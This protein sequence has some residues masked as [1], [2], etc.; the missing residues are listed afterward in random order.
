MKRKTQII[1]AAI[2]LLAVTIFIFAVYALT[3]A[4]MNDDKSNIGTDVKPETETAAAYTK[5]T[6][7]G[8]EIYN[9]PNMRLTAETVDVTDTLSETPTRVIELTAE[10]LP[11][12]AANKS[13]TWSV[14]WDY[15]TS[16]NASRDPARHVV[17][18]PL[19]DK[20]S[21]ARIYATLEFYERIRVVAT[22]TEN[23]EATAYCKVDYAQRLSKFASIDVE[24]YYGIL[25]SEYI[26][27]E[28]DGSSYNNVFE[29]LEIEELEFPQY[30]FLYDREYIFEPDYSSG[31]VSSSFEN[32]VVKIK[33]SDA[34]YNSLKAKGLAKATNDWTVIETG[35]FVTEFYNGLCNQE[36]ISSNYESVNFDLCKL[37]NSA[38]IETPVGEYD[39]EIFI[40]AESEYNSR[41][42]RFL[43]EFNRESDVFNAT[44]AELNEEI[45]I[46]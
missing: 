44:G 8:L 23:P 5:D 14:A 1:I 34:F 35:G 25:D 2:I 10:I 24:E 29:P 19:A 36:V 4:L 21:T 46:L 12:C 31:T 17:V 7:Q 6:S 39:F 33:P 38:I 42:Y 11:I 22:S 15:P 32:I 27:N 28:T 16:S 37:F 20:P 40:S 9:S 30:G 45:V 3:P 18:E 41:E 43:C 13:V 26:F